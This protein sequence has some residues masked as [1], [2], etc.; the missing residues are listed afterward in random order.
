MGGVARQHHDR[1]GVPGTE[2]LPAHFETVEIAGGVSDG[3][4]ASAGASSGA[5]GGANAGNVEH[6]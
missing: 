4:I 5:A 3:G 1:A 2:G 6:Q